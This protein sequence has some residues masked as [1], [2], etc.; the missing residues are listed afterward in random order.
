VQLSIKQHHIYALRSLREVRFGRDYTE[1]S[2]EP[3]ALLAILVNSTRQLQHALDTDRNHG[4][5]SNLDLYRLATTLGRTSCCELLLEN[6]FPVTGPQSILLEDNDLLELSTN[7]GNLSTLQFWLK[8]MAKAAE[9]ELINIGR[10]WSVK[11]TLIYDKGESEAAMYM[12]LLENL[13][14]QRT[15][16]KAIVDSHAIHLDCHADDGRLLDAHAYCAIQRLDNDCIQIP[17]HLRLH[18]GPIYQLLGESFSTV[19]VSYLELAYTI[20]FRDLTAAD[21]SCNH[22]DSISVLLKL[23][24]CYRSYQ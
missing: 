9:D 19:D 21:F 15:E 24:T 17:Y 14:C 3:E 4:G 6:R 16:L 1:L 22:N 12:A 2:T 7:S 8:A 20:G 23:V 10:L 13:S 5:Y 11:P 18:A